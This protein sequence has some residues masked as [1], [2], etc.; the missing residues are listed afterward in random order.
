MGICPLFAVQLF[1]AECF[2]A[3]PDARTGH[4]DLV[5][6]HLG[7][8]RHFELFLLTTGGI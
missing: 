8:Q 3:Q 2:L 7:G 5:V 6:Q 1:P 4:H